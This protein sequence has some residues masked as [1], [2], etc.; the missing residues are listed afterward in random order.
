MDVFKIEQSLGALGSGPSES[1]VTAEVTFDTTSD[2]NLSFFDTSSSSTPATVALSGSHCNSAILKEDYDDL[3][4]SPQ[5]CHDQV[6]D[7]LGSD[8]LFSPPPVTPP[9]PGG[10]GA[11]IKTEY[12]P[13]RSAANCNLLQRRKGHGGVNNTPLTLFSPPAH[14]TS[15]S[16]SSIKNAGSVFIKTGNYF[17]KINY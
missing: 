13:N 9:S 15:S 3:N 17:F 2:F 7:P 5:S 12:E 1:Q 11:T 6:F 8:G 10:G 16:S 4:P 14:L